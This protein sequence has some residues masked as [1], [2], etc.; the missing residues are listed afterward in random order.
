[1]PRVI[2]ITG[3]AGHGKDTV[4]AM[5]KKILG[6]RILSFADPLKNIC[7]L[8]FRLDDSDVF[9]QAGKAQY[10]PKLQMTHRHLLQK[11]G[12]EVFREHL[13]VAMPELPFDSIW[14]WHM[15]QIINESKETIIIPDLR[16]L[17]EAAMLKSH[18]AL[19]IRV[20]RDIPTE[21]SSHASETEQSRIVADVTVENNSTLEKLEIKIQNI[22]QN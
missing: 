5:I 12:T 17:D 4:A 7:K 10:N 20:V 8:L 9:T 13:R 11:M 22:I 16:F 14:V 19:I 21:I 2:G 1:M 15:D 6:G 3:Q 18:D